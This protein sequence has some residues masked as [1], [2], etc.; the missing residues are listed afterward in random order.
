MT[1]TFPPLVERS[2]YV[3]LAQGFLYLTHRSLDVIVAICMGV[4]LHIV[5]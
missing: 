3:L 2:A 1:T 4:E 5:V